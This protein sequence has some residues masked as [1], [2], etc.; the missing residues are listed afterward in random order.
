[1][2]T[3]QTATLLTDRSK[4]FQP[5]LKRL[6]RQDTFDDQCVR[7]GTGGVNREYALRHMYARATVLV[8]V[9]RDDGKFC[10]FGLGYVK[11]VEEIGKV[12][13][14]DLVC[15]QNQ[16]G[17]TIL[18]AFER[19]AKRNRIADVTALRAAVPKLVRVYERRGY[20]RA[21]DACSPPSRAARALLRTLDTN[22]AGVAGAA[23]IVVD[24]ETSSGL[25]TDGTHV[26]S[27]V[28]D[29]WRHVGR[30]KPRNVQLPEG[31]YAEEG[32][33]G[34]WMSKCIR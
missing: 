3:C 16:Q 23:R 22:A 21:A 28:A 25:Y 33:H 30:R 31:W 9:N 2:A 12:F 20:V 17:K 4:E 11:E 7:A 10:G 29:V 1:M 8:Y 6:F 18:D 26:F 15:S 14:I 34:W 13:Y 19:Y 5:T 24:G 27:S 32:G